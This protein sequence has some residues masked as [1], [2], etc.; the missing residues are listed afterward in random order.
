MLMDLFIFKETG[1]R[2]CRAIQNVQMEKRQENWLWGA[3]KKIR[4]TEQSGVKV[5]GQTA[6]TAKF[7]KLI[8]NLILITHA[9]E[10][11]QGIITMKATLR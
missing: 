3:I 9:C 10:H 1:A 4:Y 6:Q 5:K 2:S 7:L 8:K 11:E